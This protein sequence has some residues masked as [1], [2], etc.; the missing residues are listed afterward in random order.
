VAS[1]VGQGARATLVA[2]IGF[3]LLGTVCSSL[4]MVRY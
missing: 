2:A 3:S 1:G 4:R